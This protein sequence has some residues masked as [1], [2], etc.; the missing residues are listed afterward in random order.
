[1]DKTF[2]TVGPTQVHPETEAYVHDALAAGVCSLSHRG[3]A[4][5]E[6]FARTSASVKK[7]LNVPDGFHV[8]FLGSATEGIER[9]IENCVGER[10]FHLVNGAFSA[11]FF[12]TA[13]ELKKQPE[14]V[15]VAKGQGFDFASLA[16]PAEAEVVCIT[17]NETSTGVAL[18]MQEVYALKRKNPEKLFAVDIVSSAPYVD[19]DYSLIDCAFFSVQKGFGM[20]A[21]LG[22]I[23]VNDAC[24]EK[25][26]RLQEKGMNIGSYH[27][28]PVLLGY[29]AKHQ[30]PE[31]PNVL[32]IYLLGRVC[33]SYIERG[34]ERIR[35]ETDEK[36]EKIYSFFGKHGAYRP[37]VENAA[38][39]SKTTIVIDTPEGSAPVMKTLADAGFIVSSGYGKAK[40]A[41]IRIA[42]FPVHTM[43]DVEGMLGALGA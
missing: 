4:F 18:D 13:Q 35:A 30:T 39:R 22:V 1:M 12:E 24:I 43:K 42:N 11:R 14:K 5:A 9:V 31:T 36:A 38:W 37:F 16:P 21:G 29:E 34:I 8:F 23:I 17:Q 20:P 15:E 25:S 33:D 32:G 3:K 26:K 6:L 41:Q 28:F 2:F 19:V 7:L 10:S 40:D 27:N